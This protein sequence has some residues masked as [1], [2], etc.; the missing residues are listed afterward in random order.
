MG[1]YVTSSILNTKNCLTLARVSTEKCNF[2]A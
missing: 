1:K 2:A